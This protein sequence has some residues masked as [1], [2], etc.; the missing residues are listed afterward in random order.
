[1]RIP[2]FSRHALTS[3]AAAVMLAGCGG[4]IDMPLSLSPAGPPKWH[5]LSI[6]ART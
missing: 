3:G 1:M 2:R 6:R 4:G 5:A